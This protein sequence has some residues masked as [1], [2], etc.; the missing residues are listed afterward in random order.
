MTVTTLSPADYAA[1]ATALGCDPPAIQALEAVES[2]GSGFLPDG[3]P[4]L[5]YEAHRFDALTGGK[6]RGALDRFGVSLSAREWDRSLYGAGGAHQWM[7][8]DDA[9]KLDAMRADMACSWGMFQI[10]G[11]NFHMCG[12]RT[13]PDFVTAMRGSAVLHLAAFVVFIKMSNLAGPLARHD[14]AVVARGYNGPGQVDAYAAK[15][16]AAYKRINGAGTLA[17]TIQYM[18]IGADT[19]PPAM[20]SDADVLNQRQIDK[21]TIG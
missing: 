20:M 16:A 3:R 9:A 12:F 1:A 7:R 18:P 11:E 15:L 19:V 21:G 14:W 5:L 17:H 2:A 13:V 4:Q 10:L 8:H 6:F